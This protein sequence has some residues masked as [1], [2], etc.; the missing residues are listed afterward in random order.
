MGLSVPL[1]LLVVAVT[2]LLEM[3]STASDEFH[4]LEPKVSIKI[5]IY[6]KRYTKDY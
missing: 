2:E 3:G 6:F 4:K 1:I 5:Y